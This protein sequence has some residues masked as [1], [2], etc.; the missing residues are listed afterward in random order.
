MEAE[1]LQVTP[2][3]VQHVQGSVGYHVRSGN[4]HGFFY[5]G[6]MD[7]SNLTNILMATD[8][9]VLI[10]EVTF[11]D[12]QS[13]LA[14]VTNHVTPKILDSELRRLLDAGRAVP[15]VVVTHM[16][17]RAERRIARE[18]EGIG[19]RLGARIVLAFEGMLKEI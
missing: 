11:D 16:N 1:G 10:V 7:G 15:E 5:T 8:P 6:D 18:L 19:N 12:S 14:N 9:D 13:D 17:P 2:L 4:G 3:E